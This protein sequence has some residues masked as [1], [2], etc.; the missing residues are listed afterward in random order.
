MTF[1]VED[2]TGKSDAVSYT[3]V[4]QYKAYCDLRGIDYATLSDT[5]IEQILVKGTDAITAIYQMKW[6][7]Y[8]KTDTQALDF[9]RYMCK[10]NGKALTAIYLAN[11]VVPVE[12]INA[13]ILMA[14]DSL[15]LDSLVPN[16]ERGVVKESIGRNAISVEYDKYSSP[17]T[18]YTAVEALLRPYLSASGNQGSYTR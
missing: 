9:P 18:Q 10:V 1:S 14:N 17:L 7:G 11:N 6:S 5:Q 13:T 15:V 4:A 3:T 8:R 2:G 12:V 16:I